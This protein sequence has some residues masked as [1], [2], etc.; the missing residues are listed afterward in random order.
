MQGRRVTR[1]RSERGVL[2]VH[3]DERDRRAYTVRNEDR[4]SRMVVIEHPVRPGWTLDP[5]GPK[6]AETSSS[7]YRFRLTVASKQT[8][9]LDV[10]ETHA[11][12]THYS[13]DSLTDDQI[14]LILAGVENPALEQALRDH[15][16]EES[17]IA[18]I[19]RSIATQQA[20]STHLQGPAARP[21][22]HAGAEGKRRREAAPAAVRKELDEQE[23]RIVT[24]RAE[25]QTRQ[26]EREKAVRE[27]TEMIEKIDI[28]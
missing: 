5:A 9:T 17:E 6:P 21:R 28:K 24:L 15:R 27:L 8:A 7:A 13:V 3:R 4:E 18:T 14:K 10:A 23:N 1:L 12:E 11:G 20:R 25:Q 2:V 26:A 16:S 22:E 19:D